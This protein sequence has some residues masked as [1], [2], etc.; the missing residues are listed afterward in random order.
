MSKFGCFRIVHSIQYKVDQIHSDRLLTVLFSACEVCP[1][2]ALWT[3]TPTGKEICLMTNTINH[4]WI[5]DNTVGWGG[6]WG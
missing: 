2:E 3:R 4:T 1:F 5:E 6:S